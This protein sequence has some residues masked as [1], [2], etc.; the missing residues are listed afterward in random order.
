MRFGDWIL[1]EKT[2]TLN[3]EVQIAKLKLQVLQLGEELSKTTELVRKLTRIIQYKN[4]GS[5]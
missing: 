3:Q 2:D 5:S 4:Y 1:I